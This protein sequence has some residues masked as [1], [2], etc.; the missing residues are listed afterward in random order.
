MYIYIYT[1]LN[2]HYFWHPETS[3]RKVIM[4]PGLGLTLP[5]TVYGNSY[6]PIGEIRKKYIFLIPN[7]PLWGVLQ[8]LHIRK[9]KI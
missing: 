7:Y 3:K 9:T 8:L 5:P 6:F 1:K 4:V 2:E